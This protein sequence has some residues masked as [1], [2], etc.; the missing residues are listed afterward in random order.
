MAMEQCFHHKPESK[1]GRNCR[2]VFY[3][4]LNNTNSMWAVNLQSGNNGSECNRTELRC[5]NKLKHDNIFVENLVITLCLI[6]K[7]AQLCRSLSARF[8]AANH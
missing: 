8:A 5:H 1:P 4:A 6:T 3:H 2:E 7:P